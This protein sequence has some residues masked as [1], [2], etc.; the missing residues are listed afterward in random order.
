MRDAFGV[1]GGNDDGGDF[2]GLAVDVADGD[3]RLGVRA[4]PR[5]LAALANFGE[6]AP[7][8]V[9]EHDG[10]GHQLGRFVAGIAEHEAL[11]AGALL[12]SLFAFGFLRIN[13]LRDVLALLGDG[14]GD[15]DFVGVENIVVVDVADFPNGLT[16]D[17]F[18]IEFGVGGDFTGEH[19]HVAFDQCLAGH[20][21]FFVLAEAGVEDGVGN[22]VANFVG[23][24]FADRLG[25]KNVV[26][27]HW[28]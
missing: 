11:V 8:A 16:H 2:F 18:E 20:A 14:F 4:E 28:S 6:A 15:D 13:A 3:L 26:R 9:G 21:A 25:G 17:F 10:R 27:G 22:G 1:L 5:G 24:A 12:C 7:E 19:D 23:V